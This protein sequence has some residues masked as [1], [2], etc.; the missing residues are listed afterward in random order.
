MHFDLRI[1]D[2][3][4]IN[5]LDAFHPLRRIMKSVKVIIDL[6]VQSLFSPNVGKSFDRFG[7]ARLLWIIGLTVFQNHQRIVAFNFCLGVRGLVFQLDGV[8]TVIFLLLIFFIDQII[9]IFRLFGSVDVAV[10]LGIWFHATHRLSLSRRFRSPCFV[11][12]LFGYC[13][14]GWINVDRAE[15]NVILKWDFLQVWRALKIGWRTL[16]VYQFR[17]RWGLRTRRSLRV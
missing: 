4:H 13:L 2:I 3:I 17:W 9:V 10:T 7:C 6:L 8:L 11:L 15:E 14:C 1:N 16:K 12:D 5:V